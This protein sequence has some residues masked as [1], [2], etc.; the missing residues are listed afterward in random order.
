MRPRLALVVAALAAVVLPGV[1]AQAASPAVMITRIW[2]DSPG[3]DNRSNSSLNAEY[4]QLKNTTK[5][6]INIGRWT[7][8]DKAGH[9]YTV[10][11]TFYLNAG[12][13]VTLRTGKG[14]NTSSTRY[15]GSGNYIW[16]NDKDTAYVRNGS[17]TTIDSC[18]YNST[19]VD[20]TNC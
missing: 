9:V 14:T 8:R 12:S 16:N 15:W 13:T 20:Y 10:S 7:V 2:Y 17:G 4:I 6:K 19:K 3:T 1:P 5:S 11:G 18:S